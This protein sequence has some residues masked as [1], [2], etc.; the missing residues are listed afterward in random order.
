M[1]ALLENDSYKVIAS[2][3]YLFIYFLPGEILKKKGTKERKEKKK[4]EMKKEKKEE[5]KETLLL[6][7]R[8]TCKTS[9]KE[10]KKKFF[11]FPT[12]LTGLKF[13]RNRKQTTCAM[14]VSVH[15]IEI[16]Q[17]FSAISLSSVNTAN[18]KICI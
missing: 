18:H 4:K 16:V 12:T 7:G 13:W 8:Q 5:R 2:F 1:F 11:F 6:L 14:L 15:Y 3:I 17:F 10:K 9:T